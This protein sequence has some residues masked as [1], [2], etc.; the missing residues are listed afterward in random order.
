MRTYSKRKYS[1]KRKR[2]TKTK[3]R[4]SRR[5]LRQKKLRGGWGGLLNGGVSNQITNTNT[6][7]DNVLPQNG[8]W[9]GIPNV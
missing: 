6:N 1:S 9:N 5:T 4:R 7:I 8:G 3:Y 2:S